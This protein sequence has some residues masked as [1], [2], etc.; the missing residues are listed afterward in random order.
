M[1]KFDC[2][3][4]VGC[5]HMFGYE[6]KSTQEETLPSTDTYVDHIGR[7][8]DVPVYN[9]S[10]PGAS[11]QTILRRLM[12]ALEFLS[13]KKLKALL[14]LQWTEFERYETLLSD[15][16][17][18]SEDWPWIKAW[19]EMKNKSGSSKLKDWAERFYKL[20]DSKT[21]LFESLK[22]IKHANLEAQASG[23][24]VI[25]CLGDG[26]HLDGFEND[27]GYV[28]SESISSTS[29]YSTTLREWYLDN[30]YALDQTL[31]QEYAIEAYRNNEAHPTRDN[32]I[33]SL[34][35]KHITDYNW[36]FYNKGWSHGLKNFCVEKGYPIGPQ[37]HATE[38]AHRLVFEY[39][40]ESN[41][42]LNVL[43]D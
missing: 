42:F 30:G 19:A 7:H 5:S 13:I 25:N 18:T 1:K 3:V 24:L 32:M 17:Y 16:V 26:W 20:H 39:L 10:Q 12:I 34:L 40:M 23:H 36:W 15:T 43:D 6:H 29:A 31:D 11:N 2:I 27:P 28:S 4:A 9:F 21:L 22:S 33:L 35:W 41:Q 37:G 8:L 14:I 38:S